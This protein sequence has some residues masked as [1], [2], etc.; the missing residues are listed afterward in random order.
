MT[1][2]TT[3]TFNSVILLLAIFAAVWR[4]EGKIND[5]RR[6]L[7][8]IFRDFRDES[9]GDIADSRAEFK[10]DIR[11][12]ETQI[13]RLTDDVQRVETKV[14]DGLQRLARLEGRFEDR[15]ERLEAEGEADAG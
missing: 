7:D 10:N 12:V 2:D 15:E 1:F 11:R 13:Q 9:K 8:D 6:D 3:I 14:D 4:L 5:C